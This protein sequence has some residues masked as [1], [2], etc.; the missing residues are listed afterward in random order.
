MFFFFSAE[1]KDKKITKNECERFGFSFANKTS[2][3]LLEWVQKSFFGFKD[4]W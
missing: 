2:L 1:T 4:F 3:A